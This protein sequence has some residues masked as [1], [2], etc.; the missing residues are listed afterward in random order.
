MGFS[1]WLPCPKCFNP[2]IV[3]AYFLTNDMEA[4]RRHLIDMF[5]S[6]DCRGVFP[7]A[8]ADIGRANNYN[9]T[10]SIP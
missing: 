10:V 3:G 4:I 5:Q 6:P 2:L 7:H 8:R 9:H 1:D